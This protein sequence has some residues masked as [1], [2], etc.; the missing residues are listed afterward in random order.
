MKKQW[1]DYP[2]EPCPK[3]GYENSEVLTKSKKPYY[4][5]QDEEARCKDCNHSGHVEV[6]GECADIFWDDYEEDL[7]KQSNGN[8]T[9]HTM[10]FDIYTN[11]LEC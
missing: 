11:G 9:N 8:K 10:P 5:Y 6:D 4:V 3:C 2:A 7:N 1:K